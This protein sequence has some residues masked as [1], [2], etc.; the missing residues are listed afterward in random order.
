MSERFDVVVVG[1]GHG[2]AAGAIALRIGK[3]AGSI[4]IVS[5]EK[6]LPYERP[7]LSKEYLAGDKAFEKAGFKVEKK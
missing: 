1:G 4:A 5:D 7:A 6:E 2:G 3:Y